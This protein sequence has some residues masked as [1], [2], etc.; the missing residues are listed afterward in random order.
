MRAKKL[1]VN[2]SRAAETAVPNARNLFPRLY[3]YR[4]W[5]K[6]NRELHESV[7]FLAVMS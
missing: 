6:S 4:K 2:D 5:L 1:A 3:H 7:A